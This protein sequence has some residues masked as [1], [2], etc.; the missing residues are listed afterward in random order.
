M[1]NQTITI[2]GLVLP[3]IG[4][5]IGY[6]IKD[7]I[8]RKKILT[9]QITEERREL[10]QQFVNLVIELFSNTKTGKK[11]PDN[12]FVNDL[13]SFYKKY[14]LYASPGVINSFSNYFQYLYTINN[15]ELEKGNHRKHLRLLTKIMTEMRRDLGLKNRGLGQD[16]IKLLR[17]MVTDF[18]KIK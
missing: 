7:T 2:L 12:K 15:D 6:F 11:Q 5:G 18:D 8:D 3:L 4:A 10:Y 9:S 1:D 16:G 13:Y 17:A 14:I